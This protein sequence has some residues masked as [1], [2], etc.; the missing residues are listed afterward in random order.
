MRI[1]ANQETETGAGEGG[2]RPDRE[3]RCGWGGATLDGN[4]S[5]TAARI[6]VTV[7][8]AGTTTAGE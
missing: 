5:A 7:P 2:A 4:A 8:I 1:R 3:Q 6:D